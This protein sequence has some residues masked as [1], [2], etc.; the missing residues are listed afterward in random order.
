M[1]LQDD[2]YDRGSQTCNRTHIQLCHM[3]YSARM[4]CYL[5]PDKTVCVYETI[6]DDSYDRGS[7]TCVYNTI[8]ANAADGR[9][10]S[11]AIARTHVI[12]L[13]YEMLSHTQ[14]NCLIRPFDE[15]CTRECGRGFVRS[16]TSA[17]AAGAARGD[18]GRLRRPQSYDCTRRHNYR[19]F[20]R[21]GGQRVPQSKNCFIAKNIQL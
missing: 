14:Q 8:R 7:Q 3:P 15:C 6:R 1:R 13:V 16:R 20:L 4:R 9:T 11:A 12:Q 18:C 17:D 21:I 2:S 10:R 19:T 5:I